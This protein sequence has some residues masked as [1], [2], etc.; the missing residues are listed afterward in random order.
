MKRYSLH[1]LGSLLLL[2]FASC[3]NRY[4]K[5]VA[6]SP[7][8]PDKLQQA[9]VA[10]QQ[11]DISKDAYQVSA[12]EYDEFFASR[13]GLLYQKFSDT[14]FTGQIV[15]VE[16]GPDGKFIIADESWRNGKKDGPSTRWFSNGIKMYE[17]NYTDGKW[18][19]TVTRWWPNGQKMYVRAYSKG[20]RHGEEATWRSDGTPI[21]EASKVSKPI[22]NDSVKSTGL[23]ETE[24][25][26][27]NEI[28]PDFTPEV[29]QPD[30]PI[31]AS[32]Q[33]QAVIEPILTSPEPILPEPVIEPAEIALP[34]VPSLP[35]EVTITEEPAPNEP[36]PELPGLPGLESV[37]EAPFASEP[38]VSMPPLADEDSSP[39]DLPSL[40]GLPEPSSDQPTEDLSLP[41]LP[42]LPDSGGDLPPMPDSDDSLPGLPPLPSDSDGDSGGLPPLPPL[43]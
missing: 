40:P 4:R 2:M 17:R 9:S 24:S 31:I 7:A 25:A 11:V 1:A 33:E 20:V 41:G 27:N 15:T 22:L 16:D 32:P 43:P 30:L 26:V 18:N 38:D 29:A 35:S 8:S 42:G 34:D 5:N 10:K 14:P 19:G 37:E 39:S 28:M 3:E 23:D 6:G 21:K 13:Y 36:I 12:D